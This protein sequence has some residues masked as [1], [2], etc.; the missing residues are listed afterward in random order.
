MGKLT[1]D[2]RRRVFLGQERTRQIMLARMSV[3][4]PAD[5][6]PGG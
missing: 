5:S 6:D 1:P 3:A 2:E 4:T